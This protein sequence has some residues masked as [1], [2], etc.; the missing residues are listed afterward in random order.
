[1]CDSQ[2]IK[3]LLPFLDKLYHDEMVDIA[4]K[5]TSG[6]YEGL[7]KYGLTEEMINDKESLNEKVKIMEEYLKDGETSFTIIKPSP[8]YGDLA[9]INNKKDRYLSNGS[10]CPLAVIACCKG[11]C[12]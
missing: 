6:D 4:Q 1:M 7:D 8:L 9:L 3:I 2:Y 11:L 10:I 12:L 5:L